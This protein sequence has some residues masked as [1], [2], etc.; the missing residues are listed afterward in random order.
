MTMRGIVIAAGAGM[1]MRGLTRNRPKCLLE[2]AG[3]TILSHTLECL[4]AAGCAEIVV[5]T[6]H[7]AAAVTARG[8]IR[9]HNADFRNNNIL[10]S[11]MHARGYFDGPLLVSYSDIWVEPPIYASLMA[12]AGDIVLAVDR[13]WQPYYEGRSEHPVSEAEN[14]YYT[15]HGGV[16]AFGKHLAAEAPAGL[17][18]GEFLGLWRMSAAG[19]AKF[20][21][22]FEALD[23]RLDKEA[24]FEQAKKWRQAYVSDFVQHLVNSGYQV[25]CALV[26]RGWAEL[27]TE[28]DYRRLES[29]AKRQRL[30][31][32]V[33]HAHRRLDA[34]ER[35]GG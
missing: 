29:V 23:A 21:S 3:G 1:R 32:I 13:D 9:V 28:Q 7:E 31:T 17:A 4:R 2:V 5:V 20:L 15:D 30:D 26:E 16:A 14:V 24:P 25:G 34:K 27:D 10:H 18:C 12:T 11:L 6:G 8:I 22:T 33:R 35:S 19:T